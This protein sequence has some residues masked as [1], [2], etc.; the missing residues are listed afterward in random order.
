M[1]GLGGLKVHDMTKI[2][3]KEFKGSECTEDP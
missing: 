1:Q 2:I 3:C